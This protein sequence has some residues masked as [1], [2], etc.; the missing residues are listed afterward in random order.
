MNKKNN[1]TLIGMPASGKSSVGVILAK[2]LGKRFVDVDI[3]IQEKYGM[4]LKE[5][6]DRYGDERFREIE[7][8][9][10]ASLE[11]ENSVISPGG[12]VIYGKEAMAHLK[13]I[14][15]VIYLELSYY[16]IKTRLGDLRE[17]GISFRKGQ[18]LRSLYQ[19][20]VPLYEKYADMTVNEMKKNLGQVVGEICRR[21]EG[22]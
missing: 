19:E 10:N 16:A 14:S 18:S 3:L 1:I 8:E 7:N 2:R 11:V 17:R 13:K 20:R 4:R 12:S 21:Y 6:I 22:E 9:V 5:I 15:T